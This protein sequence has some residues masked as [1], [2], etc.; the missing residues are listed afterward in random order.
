MCVM[1]NFRRAVHAAC[2]LSGFDLDCAFMLAGLREVIGHLQ[3]Q[4]HLRAAAESFVE[5]A[6]VVSR[7]GS[8]QSWRTERPGH[9]R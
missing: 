5:A 3:A 2:A 9:R 1:G 4:P 8:M 7:N 6:V